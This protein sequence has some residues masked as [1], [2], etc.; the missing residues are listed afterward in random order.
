MPGGGGTVSRGTRQVGQRVSV[1]RRL[2]AHAWAMMAEKNRAAPR[3]SDPHQH[4][5]LALACTWGCSSE[6]WAHCWF[7]RMCACTCGGGT[8]LM[9]AKKR[10]SARDSPMTN[11]VSGRAAASSS[12]STD[13]PG[14]GG[15]G[16]PGAGVPP[17]VVVG[18]SS[19]AIL[20][21]LACK[22]KRV[23]GLEY[24]RSPHTTHDAHHLCL[25]GQPAPSAR[26]GCAHL[27]L[28]SPAL[29]PPP[30]PTTAMMAYQ[31]SRHVAA[32]ERCRRVVGNG[33]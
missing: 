18:A 14:R 31:D 22:A 20:V 3:G 2:G 6:S 8:S 29:P 28:R 16:G 30:P 15:G 4:P 33:Q 9:N 12:V 24:S 10:N 25:L 13:A 26:A 7:P 11:T 17:A 1:G 5:S 23:N 27:G 19:A 32:Q 21:V